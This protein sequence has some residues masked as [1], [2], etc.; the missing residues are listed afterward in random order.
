MASSITPTPVDPD[1]PAELRPF[2][3][4]AGLKAQPSPR[5]RETYA[6]AMNNPRA[7]WLTNRRYIRALAT[8]PAPDLSVVGRRVVS[9]LVTNGI[10]IATFDEFFPGRFF[11]DINDRFYQYLDKFHRIPSPGAGGGKDVFL[12]TIHKGHTLRAD[13]VVTNYLVDAGISAVAAHYFGMVPRYVGSSFWRNRP[14]TGADR[15]YSQLWHRDY[16]DRMLMKTFLYITDVGRSE[17]YFEYLTGSHE[18]GPLG[19]RF[20]RIGTDG[21]RAYPDS[22]E[23]EALLAP[24]PVYELDTVSADRHSG[25]AAPWHGQPAVV[26]CIGPKGS[27]IFADTYGLHRGG[28]VEQ[29]HRDMIMNTWST[30]AN[31]HK[32]HYV[33][34]KAYAETLSPFFRLALGID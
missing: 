4:L 25:A 10:A 20:D 18:S 32:P 27:L 1:A 29:G 33:V 22:G 17:G 26:R 30:N 2:P 19:T 34:T 9:D 31:V 16:N 15:L 28:F 5:A 3:Q 12:E 11:Q 8:I 23:V 6:R 7:F 14:A 21:F 24:L 13:E